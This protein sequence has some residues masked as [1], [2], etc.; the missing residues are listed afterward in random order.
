MVRIGKSKFFGKKKTEE[1]ISEDPKSVLDIVEEEYPGKADLLKMPF[2]Q[3]GKL[4]TNE[5]W[6]S[7]LTKSRASYER[8]WRKKQK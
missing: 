1:P 7:F 6:I 4:F 8:S 5:E 2:G 3:V